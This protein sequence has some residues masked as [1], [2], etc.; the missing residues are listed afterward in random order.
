M[1]M[2]R[3]LKVMLLMSIVPTGAVLVVAARGC[4][5]DRK[6][7]GWPDNDGLYKDPYAEAISGTKQVLIDHVLVLQERADALKQRA[8]AQHGESS[9]LARELDEVRARLDEAEKQIVT[10]TPSGDDSMVRERPEIETQLSH[11]DDRLDRAERA[12]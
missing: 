5:V 6:P 8:E 10:L 3:I 2:R 11:L 7:D 12:L 4:D 9:A 1:N